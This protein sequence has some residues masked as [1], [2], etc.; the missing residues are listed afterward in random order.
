MEHIETQIAIIQKF[1]FLAELELDFDIPFERPYEMP[2]ETGE[3]QIETTTQ[4]EPEDPRLIELRQRTKGM[5]LDQVLDEIK[6]V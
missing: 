5:S 3:V 6:K 2:G 4:P 1:Q